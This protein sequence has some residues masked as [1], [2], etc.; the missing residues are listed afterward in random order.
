MKKPSAAPACRER[1]AALLA[2]MLTVTLV[3]AF[4]ATALWQQWKA[5]EVES[6]ERARV[7]A[8]WILVGALDWS[9]LI[10]KEDARAGGADH[11]AEPWAVALQETRLSSF[12]AADKSNTPGS[13]GENQLDVF[14]SGQ[15]EDAQARMNVNNLVQGGAISKP[16]FLAFS[17]LFSILGLPQQ[18]LDLLAGRLLAL[19]AVPGGG[20][21]AAPPLLPQ[22]F[23][24]L[25]WLGI[26]PASLERLR[27][28]ACLLPV[29]TPVN[30]NTASA[31]VIQ[32]SVP[33]LDLSVAQRI[34]DQR[35]L[36]PLRNLE[37]ATQLA[38]GEAGR[39]DSARHSVATR[40]FEVRG[41]LRLE[42][43]RIEERSLLQRDGTVIKILWRERASAPALPAA[44]VSMD[45]LGFPVR[46]AAFL[47]L[48]DAMRHAD[49]LG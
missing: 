45:G 18:E 32:A 5:V 33:G 41:V 29:P 36:S 20:A 22:R 1:G 37:S 10:L 46:F 49:T 17:Q 19:Q 40:F 28:Y 44:R 9:R 14:L 4:A 34:V 11:L 30:L 43:T 23:D 13:S 27:P 39:F 47:L 6:A 31:L 21:L 3:A 2:A 15:I 42:R 48:P 12:L 38:G 7:Q 24:Q 25:A 8:A 26:A 16:D 35:A